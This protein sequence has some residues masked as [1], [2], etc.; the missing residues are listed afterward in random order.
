M[1][2]VAILMR[3]RP[4]FGLCVVIAGLAW[5]C[6]GEA[7]TL[8][9]GP[10]EHFRGVAEA[11]LAAKSGDTVLIDEGT[12]RACAVW[13]ADGLTIRGLGTGALF[14][15]QVC[16]DKAIFVVKGRNV[17]IANI[18]FMNAH[19]SD[20]NGAGIRA[21][22]RNLVVKDDTFRAD[23]DGILS[24]ND[25]DNAIIVSNSTFQHDGACEAGGCAHGIYAGRIAHLKVENCRFFD[26]QTGH[27]IKS[28]ALK[29]EVLDSTIKDGANGTSSYLIDIPNGGTLLIA[30]NILEKG[31]R[32]EN[33]SAAISIGEERHLLQSSGIA[34]LDNAMTND[35]PPTVFVRNESDTPAQLRGNAI[36]GAVRNILVGRGVVH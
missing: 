28:R 18:H 13:Q 15:G 14:D 8:R 24:D 34:V 19:S 2:S 9:V 35:G 22:G 11:A 30:G 3:L 16:D 21:E 7:A 29:T 26:T 6:F 12:Y 10:G 1:P 31:P 23:E 25:I 27:A 20:G 5:S 33:H 17:T 4:A 36:R 32:S